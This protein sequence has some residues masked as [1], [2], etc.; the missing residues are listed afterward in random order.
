MYVDYGAMFVSHGT[1]N[2][3][4]TCIN[5]CCSLRYYT[6]MLGYCLDPSRQSTDLKTC[7]HNYIYE[8]FTEQNRTNHLHI[9]LYSFLSQL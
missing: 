3:N 7:V 2:P 4:K 1:Q 6:I 8:S 9:V 5:L